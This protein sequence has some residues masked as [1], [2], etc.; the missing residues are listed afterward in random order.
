[1]NL[2]NRLAGF[3]IAVILF[4]VLLFGQKV[5]VDYDK[6][7]EF[8]KYKTYAW[9]ELGPARNEMLRLNIMGAIE[10]QLEAKGLVKVEKDADLVVAYSGDM[11]GEANRGSAAPVYPGYVGAPTIDAT[12]WTGAGGGGGMT[13]T[14]PKGTLIVELMDPHEGKIR[15][16]SV[17]QVKLDIEKKTK[18]V[19]RI[20][21]MI[22]KMFAQFPPSP[23]PKGEGR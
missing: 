14:Y 4:P 9:A 6:G 22:A 16:R 21:D 12:M 15:W 18:S 2:S 17:G 19:E 3:L 1:M 13:V 8:S 5:K 10:E 7:A 20:N 11:I 23:P